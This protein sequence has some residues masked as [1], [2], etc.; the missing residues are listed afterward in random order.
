M[1]SEPNH[2]K[3]IL[4]ELPISIAEKVWPMFE[5]AFMRGYSSGFEFLLGLSLAAFIVIAVML[6]NI[7]KRGAAP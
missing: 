2:A 4:G 1:L 7:A 3:S 6:K 5:N